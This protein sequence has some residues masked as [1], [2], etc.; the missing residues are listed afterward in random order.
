M[1][2]VLRSPVVL[3]VL[4]GWG[5]RDEKE[6]NAIALG[7]TPFYDHLWQDFP[8]AT[9]HASEENVGLP[10]GQFGNSEIGHM[11]IGA[12]RI[13]DTDLVKIAKAIRDGSF[14]TNPAFVQLFDHVK[15]HQSILHVQGLVSDGGV[16]SHQDHLEAFLIAAKAAGVQRVAIHAFTDGRDTAPQ[17]AAKFL[18][19]LEATVAKLGIGA[20]A[21]AGGRF[22]AM[23]RDNNWDRISKTEAAIFECKGKVCQFKKPSEIFEELY[24]EGVLDEHAEPVVFVDEAGKGYQVQQNDG[25]FFFN[26]RAD[27]ARQLSQRIASKAQELNL[28]FVTMT[29]YEENLP[30]LVAFPQAKIATTLAAEVSEAGLTQAHI[31][32]TEKYAHATYFLNG[33]I[34]AK[35]TGEEHILVPSRKDIPTHDLAPMMRAE[36]IADK[37]LEQIAAGTHFIFINF[38]NA[39]MVGHTANQPAMLIAV[40]EVDKQLKRVVDATTAAGGVVVI[41]ADHGNAELMIDPVTGEKH[42]AHTLNEV[43]AIITDQKYAIRDQGT[44]ADVTPTILQIMGIPQPAAMTGQSLVIK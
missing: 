18:K 7:D 5:Y 31:A 8:H 36:G 3:I 27:R 1:A 24:A 30:A 22:Y 37:A 44:L 4:D 33:G 41:T 42:T 10:I 20:I 23:D 12:G 25:V 6:N 9:L 28:C 32:E 17:S 14:A 43:P 26:F 21:S 15:K 13:I 35:H 34:E 40:A 39:D 29:Q 16:H 11:T 19:Q 2:N 38:A